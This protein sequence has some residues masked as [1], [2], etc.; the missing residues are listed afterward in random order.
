MFGQ[1]PS[2]GTGSVELLIDP[3]KLPAANIA[4]QLPDLDE[5]ACIIEPV[6]NTIAQTK[7]KSHK[8][9]TEFTDD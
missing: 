3:S 5:S 9:E 6:L 2:A 8:I 1:L 7:I 4:M